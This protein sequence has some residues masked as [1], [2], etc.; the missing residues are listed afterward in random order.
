M[1][2]DR[3]LCEECGYPLEGLGEKTSDKSTFAGARCPECGV[4]VAESMPEARVGSA[5]Q[6]RA[7]V[8]G[9]VR[10][11]WE[12]LHRPRETMRG[13]AIRGL[14]GRGL[15]WI[16]LVVAAAVLVD[17]WVGV[18]I[19][20]PARGWPSR[21]TAS[22]VA[23]YGATWVVEVGVGVAV[24]AMLTWVE[25]VGVRFFGARRGWRVTREVA[26]QVCA[27]ASVGW[28]VMGMLPLM[29][30]A[31]SFALAR[32]FGWSPSGNVDLGW[33]GMGRVP[34]TYVMNGSV[35]AGGLLAGLMVFEWLVYVGVRECRFANASRATGTSVARI[36]G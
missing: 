22:G 29:G 16:N 21:P 1:D 26:W 20:D 6:R 19:G 13:V 10:T 12:V 3:L 35:V 11:C 5:W 24:L 27:H 30:M 4:L 36:G 7:S 31:V 33:M 23:R 28:I 32:W 8:R 34:W 2:D 25:S 9:W 15:L 14:G 18:L 17:P